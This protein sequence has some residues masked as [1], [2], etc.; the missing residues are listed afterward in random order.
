ML[1]GDVSNLRLSPWNL[2]SLGAAVSGLSCAAA[3]RRGRTEPLS[4]RWRH[5]RERRPVRLRWESGPGEI[6]IRLGFELVVRRL[7][8]QWEAQRLVEPPISVVA[9]RQPLTVKPPVEAAS[10]HALRLERNPLTL[11]A[12]EARALI[13]SARTLGRGECTSRRRTFPKYA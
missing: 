10:A 9:R 6:R 7:E 3:C 8:R 2:P 13:S 4:R 5:Q 12:D 11:R 1:C